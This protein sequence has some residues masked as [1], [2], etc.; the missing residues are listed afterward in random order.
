MRERRGST[1]PT[2]LDNHATLAL[3]QN[4]FV[5]M[6]ADHCD[7]SA[8]FSA[9]V[10]SNY[11]ALVRG[12]SFVLND[13]HAA[14]DVVQ[15]ALIRLASRWE[16]LALNGL[17]LLAYVRRTVYTS[18]IDH[19][20]R[21]DRRTRLLGRLQAQPTTWADA[22]TAIDTRHDVGQLIRQLPPRQRAVIV[23]RY[24]HDLSVDEVATILS[25]SEGTVKSQTSRA[26]EALRVHAAQE[27]SD[28]VKGQP[29]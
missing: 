7:A 4:V 16:S 22:A 20:R 10:R 26:L 5:G 27:P 9:F 8:D 2:H 29:S 1:E 12:A 25:I 17:P 23:L 24:L 6:T 14:E 28:A 11:E 3:V 15:D 21:R 13:P 19:T 18:A